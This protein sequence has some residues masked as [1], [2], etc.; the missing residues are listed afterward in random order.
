MFSIVVPTWN[1]L[2]FL[3]LAVETI[4]RHSAHE[5]EILIHVN[6]GSDGTLDWVRSQGLAHTSSAG[7]IGICYAVNRA[8]ALATQ[9][10]LV[11]LNDD[12]AV[13]PGWDV[14][15]LAVARRLEGKRFMLSSTMIE[16]GSGNNRC[17]IAADFGRDAAS[18]R[19]AELIAALPGLAR[20]DWLGSTWPP[21][22]LPRWMWTEVG[23]YSVELSPG[24]GSDNDFSMKLWHAGCRTFIG[25]GD[26]FVYHFACVST[27]RIVKNDARLQF[28]HKWGISQRDFDRICLHR[29]EPVALEQALSGRVLDDADRALLARAQLRARFTLKIKPPVS[30]GAWP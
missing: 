26:S 18:F 5:H 27:G 11:Y 6:D 14:R 4:R 8:A 9:P 29:G 12:M 28:L 13:L 24:M 17:S 10:Y 25:L 21:T 3:K 22:L 2:P 20:S 7:N 15:L 16:P 30:F 1:N 23:G 19:E